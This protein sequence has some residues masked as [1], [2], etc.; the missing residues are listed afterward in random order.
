MPDQLTVGKLFAILREC[1]G[2][3]EPVADGADAAGTDFPSLGYD[4][5]ALLEATA[6][7][8]REYGVEIPEDDLAD[9]HT[10]AEFITLVN[11]LLAAPSTP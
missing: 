1:A 3:E 11:R 7:V 10:P 8:S 5:L 4:S 2:E 6:R 9:V